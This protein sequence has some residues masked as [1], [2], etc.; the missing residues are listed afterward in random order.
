MSDDHVT[1]LRTTLDLGT[2]RTT[3]CLER[4]RYERSIRDPR[5][6][7]LVHKDPG[8]CDWGEMSD[9]AVDTCRDK[10]RCVFH[11]KRRNLELISAI[12]R[13]TGGSNLN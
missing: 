11:R 8:P 10:G 7:V 13:A 1:R 3:K 2:G 12:D 6:T 9:D 5:P 4:V